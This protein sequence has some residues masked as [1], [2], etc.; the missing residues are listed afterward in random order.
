MKYNNN[1]NRNNN[2]NNNQ[3]QSYFDKEVRKNGSNFLSKKNSSQLSTDTIVA[4][5]DLVRGRVDIEK[6]GQYFF[7]PNFANAILNSCNIKH[8]VASISADGV[9]QLVNNLNPIT[10]SQ[11]DPFVFTVLD[12]HTRQQKAYEI[13]IYNLQL[14]YNTQDIGYLYSLISQMQGYKHDL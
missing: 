9:K 1:N 6:Y 5:R 12:K 8:A 10:T 7:D 2:Q 13:V 14:L 3:Q 4:L 11:T